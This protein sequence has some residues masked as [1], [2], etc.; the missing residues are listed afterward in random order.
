[1]TA[2]LFD[3]QTA[4]RLSVLIAQARECTLN[5]NLDY[6]PLRPPECA[7]IAQL[8]DTAEREILTA[9]GHTL[10]EVVAELHERWLAKGLMG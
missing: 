2:R 1:M 3:P 6:C 5:V 10:A 4:D 8:F 7:F 9:R